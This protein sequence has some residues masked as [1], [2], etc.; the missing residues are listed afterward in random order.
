MTNT[1]MRTKNS[2]LM[3]MVKGL[4]DVVFAEVPNNNT[5]SVVPTTE[6]CR[7]YIMIH[8][9]KHS[10]TSNAILFRS[11]KGSDTPRKTL[12]LFM[13]FNLLMRSSIIY[14]EALGVSTFS[15]WN[16]RI[17]SMRFAQAQSSSLFHNQTHV[18]L[19]IKCRL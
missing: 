19:E 16:V 18:L 6:I 7:K 15:T 8:G 9:K 10:V 4:G 3:M 13:L 1:T 11:S 2:P 17:V 5:P 14:V 12:P